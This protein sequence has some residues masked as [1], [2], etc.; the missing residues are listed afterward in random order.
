[1]DYE[2][3]AES[4]AN[5][6]ES[7]N[8]AA[9]DAQDEQGHDPIPVTRLVSVEGNGRTRLEIDCNWLMHTLQVQTVADIAAEL[10]CNRRTVRHRI[11]EYGLAK[12]VPPVIQEV[13]CEDGTRV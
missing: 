10:G 12:P 1:V 4:V 11:L 6:L 8:S 13:V 2:I 9:D 3:I 5:M 7:L